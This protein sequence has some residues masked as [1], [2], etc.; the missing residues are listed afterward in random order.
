VPATEIVLVTASKMPKPDTE[1]AL[2]LDALRALG[3]EA[4]LHVWDQPYDWSAVGL[5]VCR[6]PWDYFHRP[7]EFLAWAGEVA[8]CTR[9]ENPIETLVWNAHKSYLLDLASAGVPVVD[10]IL[11]PSGAGDGERG[12][13]LTRHAEPADHAE[14]V[15][16]PAVSGGAFGALRADRREPAAREHLNA[17]LVDGDALVQPLISTILR[18]GEVSLIYFDGQFSHA[19][20]KLPRPGEYRIHELYGGT[21]APYDP[22]SLELAVARAALNGA[23]TPTLYARIDLVAG[24]A[25]PLLMEAELIE[26]ELFLALDPAS[27]QRFAGCLAG[28]HRASAAVV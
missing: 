22:T 12:N 24:P 8:A 1:S 15:I 19:V 20:R 11:V 2:V 28:R 10:T 14:L 23:P 6:T 18:D 27:A 13:A 26:P 5:V 21:V 3:I 4:A 16:K 25:G 17:L 9:L 7:R